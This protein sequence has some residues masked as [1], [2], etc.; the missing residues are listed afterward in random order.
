MGSGKS[1]VAERL[2]KSLNLKLMETD[3]EIIK[4]NGFNSVTEMFVQLGQ[5][6][7]REFESQIASELREAIGV[8]VSPGGGMI[9][10]KNNC[11]NL[12]HNAVTIYLEASFDEIRNRIEKQISETGESRPLFSNVTQALNLYKERLPIYLHSCDITISTD[13]RNIAEVEADIINQLSA[14]KQAG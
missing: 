12:R 1:S 11:D 10:D 7:F 3:E 14:F 2:A 13:G 8:V 4:R 6:K 5:A 9:I